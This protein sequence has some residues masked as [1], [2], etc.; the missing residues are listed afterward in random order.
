MGRDHDSIIQD[1][2]LGWELGWKI[3]SIFTLM[4]SQL[5]NIIITIKEP[6]NI[7]AIL[8]LKG[9]MPMR[10]SYHACIASGYIP[11]IKDHIS[12]YKW[13]EYSVRIM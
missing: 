11:V 9:G 13:L 8:S 6:R 5:T 10:F 1:K 12:H 4:T 3:I 7:N 2:S